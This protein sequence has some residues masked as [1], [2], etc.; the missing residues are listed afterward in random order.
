MSDYPEFNEVT[1]ERTNE[2]RIAIVRLDG[3]T[4]NN[5][6]HL[7]L[8]REL[9][10]ALEWADGTAGIDGIVIGSTGEAFCTGA[11]VSELQELSVE[12][13][14]KWLQRYYEIVDLLRSTGKPTVAAVSG[15]CVAGGNELAMGCDLIVA[16][17]SARF[18]QPEVRVGS[19]AAGGGAQMLPLI[20]GERRARELLLTGDLL[21]ATEAE[22]IGM[23]NRVVPDGEVEVEAAALVESI[24]E[25]HS[26]QAYRVIKSMFKGWHNLA[27]L[28]WEGM[29]DLTAA[30]W[31][32]DEFGE[33]AQAFLANEAIQ[34]GSFS[35][36]SD[37]PADLDQ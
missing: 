36:I 10:R 21:G 30:V 4:P 35:G 1:I 5:I 24:I 7:E 27:M 37:E 22:E 2:D 9:I 32:S 8:I 18:G 17:E 13:G 28:H 25:T 16:G 3:Q 11:D 29:R 14:V 15:D 6:L 23:I 20:V 12:Q 19:T 34:S 33:R 26:P 31:A